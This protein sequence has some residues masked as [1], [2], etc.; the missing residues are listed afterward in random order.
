MAGRPPDVVDCARLADE[1][2]TLRRVYALEDL[3]R[4]Q[5]VLADSS[6]NATVSFAFGKIGAR[7]YGASIDV[8]AAPFLRC[9]RCLQA[10]E[11]RVAARSE[12]EFA[13]SADAA[14]ESDRE[15]YAAPEGRASLRELAEE[16]LLLALPVAPA[17]DVPETCGRAPRFAAAAA[18]AEETVRPFGILQELLK[19]P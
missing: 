14:V 9:Q 1:A 19:K 13:E 10:F 2:V 5:G 4:L 17:C 16:E 15:P 12:V 11:F 6:G 8:A 3:P 18:S 7:R